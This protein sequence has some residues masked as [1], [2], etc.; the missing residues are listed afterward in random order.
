[1]EIGY[2]RVSTT[3]QHLRMREDALKQDN[4]ELIYLEVGP[5]SRNV[6]PAATLDLWLKMT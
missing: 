3:A 4:F 6:L 2:A 1:M 5:M